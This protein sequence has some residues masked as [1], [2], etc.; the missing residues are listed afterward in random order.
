M[1]QDAQDDSSAEVEQQRGVARRDGSSIDLSASRL[2]P[3]P[4][5]RHRLCCLVFLFFFFFFP[6]PLSPYPLPPP[7][8]GQL[9][10]TAHPS[11]FAD[12]RSYFA[13]QRPLFAC[14]CAYSPRFSSP[15]SES[16]I[17]ISK[18]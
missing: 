12:S 10:C 4:S 9:V 15:S 6:P 16:V 5:P 3:S 11:L 2:H 8:R 18:S 7:A 13:S 1:D 14:H 17:A